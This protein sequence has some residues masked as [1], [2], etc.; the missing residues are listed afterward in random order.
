MRKANK[1]ARKKGHQVSNGYKARAALNI[2]VTSVPVELISLD[3]AWKI[4]SL[5]WQIELTFKIWKSICKI[6]KVKKVK[7]DRLECYIWAKLLMIVLC[8][9][10]V[11]I[12]AKLLDQ[13]Y[14]KSLSFFK[15][16]KTLLH[17]MIRVEQMF[18]DRK[19]PLGTYL[20]DFLQLSRKKHILEKKKLCNYSPE[21]L[22]SSLIIKSE[23]GDAKWQ[24]AA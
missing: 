19:E 24:I 22:V 21:V 9:R 16:F 13:Y 5:R 3:T 15:A 18:F 8:W 1:N 7:K 17:D 10:I 2:F 14:R 11:W 6:D 23:K 4:Y 12:T 20:V